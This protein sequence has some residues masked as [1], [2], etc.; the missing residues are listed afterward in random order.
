MVTITKEH[1][2]S[3]FCQIDGS[4]NCPQLHLS[5]SGQAFE[6]A[7]REW[8]QLYT[9]FEI[10]V[11]QIMPDHIHLCIDVIK[12][13]PN[14]LS[15]AIARLMGKTTNA[16]HRGTNEVSTKAFAKG[17][18]DRIA[19]TPEQWNRQKAYVADNPRRYLI[20]KLYPDLFYRRWHIKIND[21]SYLG[22][23]NIFLL[24]N[25]D[26]QVVRF[27]R[28]FTCEEFSAR[29]KRWKECVRTGGVLV[30]P[31]IHSKEKEMRDD[32][33]TA[34]GGVI[35]ICENGFLERFTPQGDEFNYNAQGQ[36]LLIAPIAHETRKEAMTYA[37]AQSLNQIAEMVAEIRGNVLTSFAPQ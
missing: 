31:F 11:Y 9:E 2:L 16:I 13:L 18:N 32:A 34:G 27:S 26:I 5:P 24:K 33:L 20:K 36:L 1:A 37:K 25:P 8:S 17:F 28:K 22:I 15:R 21:E 6:T 12:H 30:S 14:G 7:L 35:R 29:Q 23:G 3:P 19:Y 10:P 4:P